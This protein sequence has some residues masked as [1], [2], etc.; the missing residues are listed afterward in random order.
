MLVAFAGLALMS[1]QMPVF[2]PPRPAVEC[3]SHMTDHGAMENCLEGLLRDAE[4]ALETA[5]DA[6]AAEADASDEDSGGLFD[7]GGATARAQA[8]WETYRDAECDRR[9]ALMFVSNEDRRE[10]VLDCQISLTRAR[11]RELEAL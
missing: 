9:G 8:A 7:A 3:S 11:T 1:T 10:M 5:V 6:A 4:D 2:Q